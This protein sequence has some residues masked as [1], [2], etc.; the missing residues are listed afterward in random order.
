MSNSTVLRRERVA[1]F[2]GDLNLQGEEGRELGHESALEQISVDLEALRD[3]SPRLYWLAREGIVRPA[4]DRIHEATRAT[5]RLRKRLKG[6]PN[7]PTQ[8]GKVRTT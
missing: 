3:I 6:S 1:G 8:R 4:A 7:L 5:I 2:R